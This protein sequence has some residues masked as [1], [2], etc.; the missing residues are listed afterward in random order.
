MRSL[1]QFAAF[2][3]IVFFAVGEFLG[4]W[5]LGVPPQTPVF[6]YKKTT[7]VTVTRRTLLSQQF[8]FDVEGRLSRGSLVLEGIYERPASFQNSSQQAQAPKV[9]FTETFEQ[10]E[11]IAVDE[12]LKRGAGIYTL[13]F[14]YNDASGTLH[15]D[16]PTNSEL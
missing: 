6:L 4:G 11:R 8:P 2:L 3:T 7:T 1:L 13:R 9:Y 14:T 10:G 5:Y 12:V 16:V 15:I